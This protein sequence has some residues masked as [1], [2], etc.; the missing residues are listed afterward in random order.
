MDAILDT[1]NSATNGHYN[2]HAQQS[3]AL[4]VPGDAN[5]PSVTYST[6]HTVANV[7]LAN[8]A[9]TATIAAGK[10]TPTNLFTASDVGNTITDGTNADIP[11]GTT[12]ASFIDASHVTLSANA[13]VTGTKSVTIASAAGSFNSQAGSSAGR[14]ALRDSVN[15]IYP[16]SALGAGKGCVDIARSSADSNVPGGTDNATA[17]YYAFALDIVNWAS[18]SLNA[19]ASLTLQQLRDIYNCKITQWNELPGGGQGQ[20][21][22]VLAQSNSGT[23]AS[24]L[25]RVL[26][27]SEASIVGATNQDPTPGSVCPSVIQVEENHGNYLTDASQGGNASLYQQ[28]IMPYSNGKWVFQATNAANPTLDIRNGVRVGAITTTPGDPTTA[29][30]GVRWSGS[31][32][33]LNNTGTARAQIATDGVTTSGSTTVTSATAGFKSADTGLAISGTGIPSGATIASVTNSTTVVLSAAATSSN[34]GVTLTISGIVAS[35]SNPNVTDATETRIFAGVRYL[36]NVLDTGSPNYPDAL[37]VVGFDPSSTSKSPLCNGTNNTDILSAGFL[38]LPTRNI[39]SNTGV[40]C[41]I[42]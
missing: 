36:Y 24:Y 37:A 39:G 2:V 22:R 7:V 5:C 1:A 16:T 12:V 4:T 23:E 17:Q 33:F 30:Y 11:F 15:G 34:T 32:F 35:E 18:P 38:D 28:M 13:G 9:N 14:R 27:A 10:Q 3:P 21:Q 19:P 25:A 42:V 29:A 41:R 26:G 8:G 40:T 6:P 20:I 31:R